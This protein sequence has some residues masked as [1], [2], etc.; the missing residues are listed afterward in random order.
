MGCFLLLLLEISRT[1]P[2]FFSSLTRKQNPPFHIHSAFESKYGTACFRS[3][4]W[5]TRNNKEYDLCKNAQSTIHTSYT[6]SF[7]QKCDRPTGDNVFL[8]SCESHNIPFWIQ[9]VLWEVNSLKAHFSLKPLVKSLK[10]L[11]AEAKH[12]NLKFCTWTNTQDLKNKLMLIHRLFLPST[13][14]LSFL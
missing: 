3:V 10:L 12:W 6:L 7:F 9:T 1:K 14:D 4:F 5:S 13:C 11:I 8:C 2:L